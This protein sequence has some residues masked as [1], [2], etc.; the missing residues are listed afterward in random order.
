MHDSAKVP[1]QI[2]STKLMLSICNNPR[3]HECLPDV[4]DISVIDPQ[5]CTCGGNSTTSES[6]VKSST[7]IILSLTL[8]LSNDPLKEQ[9]MP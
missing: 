7:Q 6:Q 5:R 9:R 1:N 4:L 2:T 8:S 3:F